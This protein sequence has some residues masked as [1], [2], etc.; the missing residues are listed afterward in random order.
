MLDI[1]PVVPVRVVAVP[2]ALNVELP[3]LGVSGV[4]VQLPLALVVVI[5]MLMYIS[6]RVSR[7]DQPATPPMMM[8]MPQAS[9]TEAKAM[10]HNERRLFSCGAQ[11]RQPQA[12]MTAGTEQ[13]GAPRP[14][15][16]VESGTAS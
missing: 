14:S 16:K 15:E 13:H 10:A 6:I 9:A 11:Q 1:S 7:F 2:L 8:A 4:V 5:V 12:Q 3:G